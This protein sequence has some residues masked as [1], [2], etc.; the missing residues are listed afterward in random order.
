MPNP[1]SGSPLAKAGRLTGT[2]PALQRGLQVLHLLAS[3][4]APV[5]AAAIARELG[6]PRSSTYELLSELARAGFAV[7]LAESRRWGLGLAAFEVGS[8]YLRGQPL[9]RLGTPVLARLAG[10]TG[11]T[12]HLGVLHGNQTLYLAKERPPRGPSLVTAVGVRLPAALT[13]TGTAI[14]AGLSHAQVRALFPAS[15]AFV[16]RTG[17]GVRTLPELRSRLIATRRRGWAVEDGEVAADT[18]SVAVAVFDHN[19]MPIA[20]IGVTVE[21]RCPPGTSECHWDA[22]DLARPVRSAGAALSSSIGGRPPSP[23][24][25]ESASPDVAGRWRPV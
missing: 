25:A 17:R 8:A 7:H 6:L 20:A 22:A 10:A 16:I 3:R 5:S 2:A 13:A 11:G 21:H 14:L 9:E 24:P 4:A 1:S 23:G 15:D 12:A 19:G 18:A